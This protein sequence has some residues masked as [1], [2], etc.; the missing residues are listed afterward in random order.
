MRRFRAGLTSAPPASASPRKGAR[1]LQ[2]ET[3]EPMRSQGVRVLGVRNFNVFYTVDKSA[4]RVS[5]IRVI[6]NR[7]NV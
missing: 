1:R 2:K 4:R 7:R 3:R 5:V 6:Y